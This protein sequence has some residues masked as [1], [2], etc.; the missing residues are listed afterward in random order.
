[1]KKHITAFF[2]MTVALGTV[3]ILPCYVLIAT[4]FQ[5]ME[6]DNPLVWEKQMQQFEAEDQT[7]EAKN[8]MLL[9][10]GSSSIRFWDNLTE[11]FP[12][13]NVL[14]RGFGGAKISDVVYYADQILSHHKPAAIVL[15]VGTN[16]LSGRPNDKTPEEVLG[17]FK[18]LTEHINVKLPATKLIYL[19]ITPTTSRWHVWP[20]VQ[21]ANELIKKYCQQK[22]NVTFVDATPHFLNDQQE[23]NKEFLWWDGTHL[24]KKG[25]DIWRKLLLHELTSV[26]EKQESM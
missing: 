7:I 8:N 14:N 16:D 11:Q 12:S 20:H 22:P 25:Y 17:Y 24:N 21:Y 19:S 6:S 18:L 3:I 1:M 10:V 15:F 26:K 13:F 9:F 5:K 4:E 23:P 2:L